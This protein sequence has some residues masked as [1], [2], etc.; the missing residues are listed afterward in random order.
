M[1]LD[2]VA[3]G[4]RRYGRERDAAKRA[5]LLERLAPTGDPRVREALITAYS[6]RSET[7][8]A[9]AA[10]LLGRHYGVIAAMMYTPVE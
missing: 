2:E 3:D 5:A 10:A 1:V 9:T 4:L 8:S 6:D 7:V